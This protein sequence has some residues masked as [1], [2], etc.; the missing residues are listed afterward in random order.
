MKSVANEQGYSAVFIDWPHRAQNSS[1]TW[2]AELTLVGF[3]HGAYVPLFT[4]AYGFNIESGRVTLLPLESASPSLFHLI[5]IA[6][7]NHPWSF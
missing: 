3:I 7:A 4:L 5:N 6:W 2:K 1:V